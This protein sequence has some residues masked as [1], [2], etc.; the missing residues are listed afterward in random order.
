[1]ENMT[2]QAREAAHDEVTHI[3]HNRENRD[4]ERVI[5]C[6]PAEVGPLLSGLNFQ[7]LVDYSNIRAISRVFFAFLSLIDVLKIQSSHRL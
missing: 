3:T 5:L 2:R 1:M 4:T 6:G 7:K